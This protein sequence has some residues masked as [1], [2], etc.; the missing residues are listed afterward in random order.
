MRTLFLLPLLLLAPAAAPAGSP[1]LDTRWTEA[2][3]AAV[4]RSG[5]QIRLPEVRVYDGRGRLL[6]RNFGGGKPGAIVPQVA[7]ALRG[8]KTIAGPSLT[9]SLRAL[10]TR[11][12][13]AALPQLRGDRRII[14]IDYWATW[15]VGC[16]VVSR[17][18]AEWSAKQGGKV[19][20]VRAETDPMQGKPVQHRYFDKDGKEIKA[21]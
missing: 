5:G 3:R 7:A 4:V 9:E 20:L 18:L 12:G 15:C 13:R 10:E 8:G 16:K 17:E 6:L 11:D 2:A 19:L 1:T 21:S 14:V